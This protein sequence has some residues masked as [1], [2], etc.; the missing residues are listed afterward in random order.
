MMANSYKPIFVS[1][2]EI[3]IHF[4]NESSSKGGHPLP[5]S[6]LT[7]ISAEHLVLEPWPVYMGKL[8]NKNDSSKCFILA[9]VLNVNELYSSNKSHRI[10]E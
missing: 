9:N 6:L 4:K 8:I 3:M 7:L 2:A 1:N 5:G 10:A